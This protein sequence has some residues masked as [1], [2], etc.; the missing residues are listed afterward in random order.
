MEVWLFVLMTP[1]GCGPALVVVPGL[2]QCGRSSLTV[3]RFDIQS[4]GAIGAVVG[5][6]CIVAGQQFASVGIP[7][8]LEIFT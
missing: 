1:P 2:R 5:I 3:F 6:V 8:G 4:A 7:H